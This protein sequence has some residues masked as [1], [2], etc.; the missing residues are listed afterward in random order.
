MRLRE[1]GGE[2][3]RTGG[4]GGGKWEVGKDVEI[5]IGEGTRHVECLRS[6]RKGCGNVN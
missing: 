3:A 6:G 4:G 5:D 1:V 2:W